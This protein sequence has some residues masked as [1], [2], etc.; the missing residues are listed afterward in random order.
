MNVQ[1]LPQNVREALRE[2]KLTDDDATTMTASEIFEVFCNWNG[3]VNWSGTLIK[4]LDECRACEG[5]GDSGPFYGKLCKAMIKEG[6]TR[7]DGYW[8]DQ[9]GVV[10]DWSLGEGFKVKSGP[11]SG[12]KFGSEAEAI[13]NYLS[14][15]G[16]Y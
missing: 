16:K 9:D 4:V 15:T 10:I 7:Y 5:T 2:S 12:H 11:K 8:S 6:C 3:L 14:S 13:L 1:K